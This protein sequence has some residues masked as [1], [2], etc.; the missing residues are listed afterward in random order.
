MIALFP[1][2]GYFAKLMQT[3]Q[4]KKMESVSNST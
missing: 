4:K 2:P 1:V 3:V